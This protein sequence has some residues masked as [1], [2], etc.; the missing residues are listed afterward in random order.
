MTNVKNCPE[1][2]AKQHKDFSSGW[3]KSRHHFIMMTSLCGHCGC[4]WDV[5][6]HAVNVVIDD[7]ASRKTKEDFA[8]KHISDMRR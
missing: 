1:C 6:Y 4:V 7:E 3:D 2:G 5:V 8:K